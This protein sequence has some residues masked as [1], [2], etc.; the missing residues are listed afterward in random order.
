MSLLSAMISITSI[1]QVTHFTWSWLT[2]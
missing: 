1:N 2:V